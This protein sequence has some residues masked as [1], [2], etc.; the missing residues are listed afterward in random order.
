MFES[1]IS[2]R[3]ETLFIQLTFQKNFLRTFCHRRIELNSIHEA[4]IVN[5]ILTGVYR[6]T[7]SAH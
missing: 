1:I 3:S 7:P 2:P 6:Y 5:R 4:S